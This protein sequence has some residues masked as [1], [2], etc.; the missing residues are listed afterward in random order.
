MIDYDQAKNIF[1]TNKIKEE[2]QNTKNEHI[3]EDPEDEL[4]KA[5]S[6]SESRDT[7][8]DAQQRDTVIDPQKKLQDLRLEMQAD[9]R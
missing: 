5:L 3:S 7:T 9:Q 2:L 1:E 4:K 8:I 6:N